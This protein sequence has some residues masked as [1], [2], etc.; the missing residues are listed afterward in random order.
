M[1]AVVLDA[2]VIRSGFAASRLMPAT[3]N[4]EAI[5]YSASWTYQLLTQWAFM[6]KYA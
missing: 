6:Q 3:V 2:A 4:R 1:L 5:H